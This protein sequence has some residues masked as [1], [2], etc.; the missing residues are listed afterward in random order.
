MRFFLPTR[1][2]I[3]AL[4][5]AGGS[6]DLAA[7]PKQIPGAPAT[8]TRETPSS[9]A[10]ST[11]Q[12]KKPQPTKQKPASELISKQAQ[13]KVVPRV[14]ERTNPENS[15]VFVSL[16]KQR[17]YLMMGDE[18]AIDT[19]VSTGKK[20]GMTPKGS[21]T[22]LE[23]DKDHR[24]NIYGNFVNSRGQVVRSGVSTRVDSAPSGTR[25]Q[26][27]PMQ[28]FMRLTWQGVG[29]HVGH[30][31]GYPASHGCIRMPADIAPLFYERVKIGTPVV[32][33]D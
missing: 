20:A 30:L 5:V 24:S 10:R 21:F 17:A 18:I 9:Q 26:G 23:K 15:R 31:P 28:F 27:A 11:E 8:N 29:M 16:G 19:P 12:P 25:F 3:L 4:L 6:P 7:A 14:L 13:P 1:A 22:V 2:A 33:D 32:I